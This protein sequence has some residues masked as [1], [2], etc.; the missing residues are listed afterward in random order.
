M[1]TVLIVDDEKLFLASL[2]EGLQA[3]S[4]EFTVVTANNGREA[5]KVLHGQEIA[6][7]I[8]D[9]KMPIM[10]GFQLLAFMLQSHADVPVIV[11]TAFGTPEIEDCIMNL[12]ASGYLEKPIDFQ[13]LTDRIRAVIN[14]DSSGHLS[15]ITLSSFLQL[16]HSE[17]KTCMLKISSKGKKGVFDFL[18]GDLVDAAFETLTGEAAA[19]KIAGWSNVQIEIA[20]AFKKVERRITK[21]LP[22]ILAEAAAPPPQVK[23]PLDSPAAAPLPTTSLNGKISPAAPQ[24]KAVETDTQPLNSTQTQTT[25]KELK[26]EMAAN[27]NQ[28]ISDLM[29]IDGSLAVAL[30]DSNSGMALGQ[31]GNSIN[32]E[33]AAAGNSEVVKSK[34]KVMQSLGLKDK[35]EDILIT[36]GNQYH[37]IRPLSTHQNLFF[38]LVLDRTK[39][40]LAMARFKLTEIEKSVEV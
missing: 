29:N 4:D 11:M 39:S 24:N 30:V 38:Y 20:K 32:L 25:R 15:G 2:T 28:S 13:V 31:A 23:L 6:L 14:D 17:R 19:V 7:V 27:L 8:T 16:L 1:K 36:L 3:Y 33:V 12:D 40:N 9:L 5:V 37:L 18:E 35:I 10:D 34:N 22:Q 21:T 26:P